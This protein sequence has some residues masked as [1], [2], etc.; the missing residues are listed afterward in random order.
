MVAPKVIS[1]CMDASNHG[2][3]S[4]ASTQPARW[5]VGDVRGLWL[6]RPVNLLLPRSWAEQGPWRPGR[7]SLISPAISGSA[8]SA[9][10]V[11]DTQGKSH[12]SPAKLQK[13][14]G[15]AQS[16]G[17]VAGWVLSYERGRSDE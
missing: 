14:M 13:P 5:C 7:Q 9:S 1:R 17:K 6:G 16:P 8:G 4:A 15:I 11:G 3:R 2:R 12:G 10:T